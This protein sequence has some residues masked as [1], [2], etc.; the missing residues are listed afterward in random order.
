MSEQLLKVNARAFPTYAAMPW[1]VAASIYALLLAVGARLLNDPDTYWHI[2]VGRWIAEH[3]AVPTTDPFSFTMHGAHWIAFEWLSE[4]LYAAAFAVG[5]WA[6]VVVLAAA[7]I[8]IAFGL[9]T[10]L[11]LR[12]LSPTPA[13]L[14]VLAALVLAAPHMLA[15]PHVLVLPIMVACGGALVRT[16]DDH[17]KPPYAALPLLVLWANLHGS[18]VL[19]LGMIGP[20]V[21]EA[22]L[23]EPRQLWPRVI[24]RWIPFSALAVLASCLTPYGAGS[25]LVP[26]TTFGLGDALNTII[27][28]RPQDFS[29]LDVFEFLLLAS[30]F[31]LSRGF[32]VPPVRTLVVLGLLHFAL[33]HARNT[34]LLAMLAPL[35][36]AAPLGRQMALKSACDFSGALAFNRTL[37][38]AAAGVTAIASGIAFA[39]PPLPS[40]QN[41]PQAAIS[42]T[43]LAKAGPVL[44]DYSFG[45]Y[46][47]YSGIAP[48]IDGRGELYGKDFISRYSRAISLSNLP[49]FLKLLD[50]YGIRATLLSPDTPAVAL[51]DRLPGWK[52]VYADRVAVVHKRRD[53]PAHR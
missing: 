6:G 8:A 23:G 13:L 29:H 27:E 43:G 26:L 4:L 22:L 51:L 46:L 34:D 32:T 44:N 30:I 20:A 21:L 48:F 37:G 11:L 39:H 28:W 38:F 2:A 16:M 9:L 31:A 35:Y 36:L 52:R 50:Q 53:I 40:A 18:V 25:L 42:A 49:D 17:G 19:G 3:H 12:E 15:R 10:R 33:A 5:G 14:L 45:G 1:L 47:I 7:A 24:L 41:T